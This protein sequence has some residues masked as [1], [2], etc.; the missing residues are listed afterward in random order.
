MSPP[1]VLTRSSTPGLVGLKKMFTT[2]PPLSALYTMRLYNTIYTA[3]CIL[4]QILNSDFNGIFY[5][6]FKQITEK[7]YG[8]K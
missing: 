4:V 2:A 3:K 8:P 5:K 6:Y 1:G 7:E